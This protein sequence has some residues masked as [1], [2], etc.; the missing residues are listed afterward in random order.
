MSSGLFALLDDIAAIAKVAAASLDDVAAQATKA[1]AK[2][3]GIVI[4][5]A[6]VTPRYAM[7]F[8][9]DR[10][11]P[12][13]WKIARGS[14][15]NKIY[16]LLPGALILSLVA[17]FLITP[18]LMVGGAYLCFEGYEKAHEWFAP[19]AGHAEETALNVTNYATPEE[20]AVASLALEDEKTAGAIR[21]DFILSGEI[22][23]ITLGTVAAASIWTKVA[24]LSVVGLG[25]TVL[26]YGVV[27]LIVKAD[28]FG[29]MLARR[30]LGVTRAIGRAIVAGMPA[31]L[32]VLSVVG[33]LAMLW[34]GGGIIIHGL[35]EYGAGALEHAIKDGAKWAAALVPAAASV[36]GWLTEAVAAAIFGAI[37]GALCVPLLHYVLEPLMRALK[38]VFAKLLVRPA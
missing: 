34:V 2:A 31:F 16:F 9:A 7:G 8:A 30:K 26:V 12:I 32:S 4:D 11:L 5:D 35:A 15:K 14:L 20:A 38:P 1:G 23:A 24:V 25:M 6:A 17:P 19:H 29:M 27:A 36:I 3:A 28:D 21:T 22:M 13:I 33:T 18:I 37:I 10:E